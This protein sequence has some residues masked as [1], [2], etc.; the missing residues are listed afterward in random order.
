MFTIPPIALGCI[1][2]YEV[3]SRLQWLRIVP[4]IGPKSVWFRCCTDFY[5]NQYQEE[6]K[7]LFNRVF[8]ISSLRCIQTA[9]WDFIFYI[10]QNFAHRHSRDK[11]ENIC[12]A[13]QFDEH[14]NLAFKYIR[15]FQRKKKLVIQSSLSYRKMAI[16]FCKDEKTE[17]VF[18]HHMWA[19]DKIHKRSSKYILIYK[20]EPLF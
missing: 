4:I 18:E 15:I 11:N 1:L 9:F 13:H 19:K 6:K 20:Y 10:F 12:F 14:I 17:H 3:F 16:V 2:H 7:I 5:T 8:R